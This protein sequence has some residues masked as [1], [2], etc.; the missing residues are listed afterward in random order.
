MS[1][2]WE[3]VEATPSVS[4]WDATPGGGADATP[5]G[6][7]DATPG[8][9]ESGTTPGGRRN[10]WDETPTPRRVSSLLWPPT[11]PSALAHASWD[12][13]AKACWGSCGSQRYPPLNYNP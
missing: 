11:A 3:A 7:W 5:G 2:D 4:R 8:R 12:L 9:A 6:R 13:P 1:S 10:R